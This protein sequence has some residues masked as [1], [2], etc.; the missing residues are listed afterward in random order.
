MKRIEKKHMDAAEDWLLR[1]RWNTA[2]PADRAAF[3]R[4]HAVPEHAAAYAKAERLWKSF[5]RLAA[6]PR[7]DRMGQRILVDA[8]VRRR[9]RRPQT[10]W[11]ASAAIVAIALVGYFSLQR[12][13]PAEGYATAPGE[14]S[15]IRLADGSEVV[16]N[17]ATRLEARLGET[18]RELSLVQG[19]A[20]FTVANDPT[21]PFFVTA[22]DGRV[23]ALGTRFQ[24]RHE[25]KRV[26]V[27]L[28]EGRIAVDRG[29]S[30]H[31]VRLK[32]DEQVRFTAASDEI[33]RRTVDPTEVTSWTTGRLQFHSTL[34]S[35][36]LEEVNRYAK[37][38]IRLGDPSL[39]N[40]AVN[41][42]FEIG[43]SESLVAALETAFPITAASRDRGGI[44]LQ[45]R[46]AN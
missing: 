25:S 27:T 29:D 32:P 13:V 12:H 34:L 7:I 42:T 38:K 26:T 19:E 9:W 15:T 44:V 35:E 2:T 40:T 11:A 1:L 6:N 17:S 3:E 43:D 18:R 14:R 23:R 31:D 21:R 36:V 22:G 5:D 45:K 4:W 30:V 39:G 16:L 37:T 41:G 46:G 28:L 33:E 24:V 20:I 8:A 10:A